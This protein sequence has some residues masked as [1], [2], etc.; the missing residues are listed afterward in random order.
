MA[1]TYSSLRLLLSNFSFYF[2]NELYH[3]TSPKLLIKEHLLWN[4]F[5]FSLIWMKCKTNHHDYAIVRFSIATHEKSLVSFIEITN[6][7]VNHVTIFLCLEENTQKWNW[8]GKKYFD[9]ELKK[10]VLVNLHHKIVQ[11][12]NPFF[13]IA[14]LFSRSLYVHHAFL[15]TIDRDGEIREREKRHTS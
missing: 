14:L 13:F 10:Q 7:P 3:R 15:I 11:N 2:N 1:S 5:Y 12:G 4:H 6:W 8:R 9:A